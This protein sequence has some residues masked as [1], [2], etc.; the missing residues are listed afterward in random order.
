MMKNGF[1]TWF[2]KPQRTPIE[3]EKTK[4]FIE[5]MVREE[6]CNLMPNIE[7]ITCAICLDECEHADGVILR[8]NQGHQ[9]L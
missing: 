7:R 6:G 8:D 2:S 5:L 9:Y 4:E 1:F 3:E